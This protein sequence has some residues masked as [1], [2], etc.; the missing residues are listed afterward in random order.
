MSIET[1]GA[2]HKSATVNEYQV[3]DHAKLRFLE[4]IDAEEPFPEARIRS[5]LTAGE[6]RR[7]PDFDRPVIVDSG[8]GVVVDPVD[9]IAVTVFQPSA[10][11]LADGD[12]RDASA[13]WREEYRHQGVIADEY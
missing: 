9:K 5:I 13:G 10:T 4:R 8:V 1:S 6:H 2:A 7:L 11:Q 3:S 12:R